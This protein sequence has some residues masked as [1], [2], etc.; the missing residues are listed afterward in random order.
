MLIN[1]GY[2]LIDYHVHL[3]GGLTLEQVLEKSRKTGI[4][5]GIAPNCGVGFEIDTNEKLEEYYSTNQNMPVFLSMQAE[6][7]EWVDIF[8]KESIAKFD[9]V[10]T[11]AM[12]FTND[13]GKRMR[14]WINEE[15]EVGDPQSFMDMY[16][17]RIENVLD[18]EKV[19]IYVN[20][21]F[22]PQ[23]ISAQY[24]KLW[25]EERMQKVT[26]ALARNDIALEINDRYRIPHAPF[27][28]MA[29]AKGVK[30]AFGTN[31]VDGGQYADLDYCLEM[32]EE[33]GIVPS[34]MFMPRPDGKKPIQVKGVLF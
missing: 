24:D 2:P 18:N 29:K 7:R 33:C 13:N 19:D 31:N 14:L 27:I 11:D 25:T 26:D 10:F 9:Y 34:D 12:T 3:K 5:C 1:K 17:N 23:E 4:Y 30:F 8:K 21:I 22:L 32:I 6:G 28:K 16:V 20:P 15:V